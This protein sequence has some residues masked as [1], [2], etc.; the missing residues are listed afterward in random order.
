MPGKRGGGG[1]REESIYFVGAISRKA[2][3]SSCMFTCCDQVDGTTGESCPLSARSKPLVA[4]LVKPGVSS[5]SK[6]AKGK[7]H[8]M[9]EFLAGDKGQTMENQTKNPPHPP[10]KKP[11]KSAF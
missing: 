4:T 3:G 11:N 7:M 1:S 8:S 5:H 6:L 10:K 2:C 9:G